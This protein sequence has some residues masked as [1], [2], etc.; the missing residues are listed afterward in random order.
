MASKSGKISNLPNSIAKDKVS[1]D[2]FENPEKFPLGPTIPNPG[3]IFPMPVSYTHLTT[4]YRYGLISD[5]L[6][7]YVGKGKRERLILNIS[8]ADIL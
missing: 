7:I 5:E 6:T 4:Q 1:F 3:P 8:V 2:R